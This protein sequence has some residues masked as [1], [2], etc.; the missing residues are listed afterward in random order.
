VGNGAYNTATAD[1]VEI[2]KANMGHPNLTA[3]ELQRLE[4][5]PNRCSA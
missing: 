1:Y 2:I 4:I 5:G 3:T